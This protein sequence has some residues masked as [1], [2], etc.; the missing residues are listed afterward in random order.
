MINK[1]KKHYKLWYEWQKGCIN[2][3]YYKL[4]VLL[5]LQLSPTFEFHKRAEQFKE[6]HPDGYFGIPEKGETNKS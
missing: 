1:L 3:W 6:E 2:T 5:G 4:A